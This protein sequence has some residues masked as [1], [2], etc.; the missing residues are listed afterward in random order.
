MRRSPSRVVEA[1]IG[2]L[3]L[4]LLMNGCSEPPERWADPVP[5]CA[6]AL[7]ELPQTVLGRRR[8]DRPPNA[9]R[10]V[11]AGWGDPVIT[12]A[13]GLDPVEPTTAPCLTVD[14]VDWIFLEPQDG[15]DLSFRSYGTSLAVEVVVP[16]SYGRANATGALV[17]LAGAARALPKNGRRCEG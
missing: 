1:P 12:V 10:P 7:A 8:L 15:G 3:G 4:V 11:D 5:A 14:G 13:C 9:G 6:P 17:D 2:G 16:Q